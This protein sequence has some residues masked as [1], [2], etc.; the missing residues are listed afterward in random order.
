MPKQR[1]TKRGK[2]VLGIALALLIWFISTQ[3]WV[4]ADGVCVGD[5]IKCVYGG[6]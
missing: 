1:L 3:L 5:V 4:N 6:K 2:I